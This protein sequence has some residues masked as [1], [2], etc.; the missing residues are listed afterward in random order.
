MSIFQRIAN[1]FKDKPTNEIKPKDEKKVDISAEKRKPE[2]EKSQS[3]VEIIT[4]S[5]TLDLPKEKIGKDG[6]PMVLIPAGEFEMG[7]YDLYDA[8]VRTVY[9]D[10]FYIDKYEITNA[11]YKKFMQETDRIEPEGC[12]SINQKGFRPLQDRNF[13]GDNQPIV[14]VSWED[15]KAYAE[16]AGRRLP[17]E[18]E[19]EKAA[20]GGLVG[21]KYV[22]GDEWPPPKGAGNFS[23]ET[24][25]KAFSEPHW[26]KFISGYDDGYVYTS[27][28]GSFNPNGYGLYDM[29]GNVSEWCADWY[30]DKYYVS[31]PKENPTGP[32]SGSTRVARGGAYSDNIPGFICV[33]YRMHVA[34][35]FSSNCGGFRCVGL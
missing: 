29:E 21:K 12:V 4:P 23:D 1:I 8:M 3:V 6:A 17:T 5:K 26:W 28:V 2:P 13:N 31:S 25:K 33:S 34:P 24:A 9:L 11:Q 20:K 18:A 16:W 7:D 35:T 32:V 15:A 10:A 19:W 14:C 22:W 30:N 27:P